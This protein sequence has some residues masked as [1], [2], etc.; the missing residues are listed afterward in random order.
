[1]VYMQRALELAKEAVGISSPNPPVGAVLV[2][3]GQIVGEGHT[4]PPGQAHAEIIAIT[5]AGKAANGSSLYTTLEPCC[6]FGKTP[7]CTRQIIEAGIKEVHVAF[8]DPNPLVDG[9]G[10][11][12]LRNAGISIHVDRVEQESAEIMEGYVKVMSSGNPFVT[13]KFAMS[14]DG[15]IST[16]SGDS[17]WITSTESRAIA[18]KLRGKADAILVGIGTVLQ[19]DPHLTVRDAEENLYERQPVRI[20]LDSYGRLPLDAKLLKEPGLSLIVATDVEERKVNA[21]TQLGAEVIFVSGQN[22]LI[23]LAELMKLLTQRGFLSLIVEGGS[24][25]LGS[26][27]DAGLV[28]KVVGFVSP[29]ILGGLDSPSPVGG[30]GAV[31][32]ADSFRL[33]RSTIT[34]IGSDVMITGYLR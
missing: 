29:I 3:N 5:Q 30:N 6:H 9:K 18:R 10:I 24:Q 33:E 8:I 25:I 4:L 17:K 26:F 31:N 28:D 27:F 23:D 16:A 20:I 13:A 1:M 21:L 22:G 2:K 32:I 11:D 19:D 15:K 7:P 14:L 12:E 34:T